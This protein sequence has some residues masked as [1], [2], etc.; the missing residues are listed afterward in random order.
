MF[1]TALRLLVKNLYR[2]EPGRKLVKA[3]TSACIDKEISGSESVVLSTVTGNT[4]FVYHF[5]EDLEFQ[6][7]VVDNLL[8]QGFLLNSPVFEKVVLWDDEWWNR[9]SRDPALPEEFG[10]RKEFFRS[11]LSNESVFKTFME[12]KWFLERASYSESLIRELLQFDVWQ[13]KLLRSPEFIAFAQNSESLTA[14]MLQ[15]MRVIEQ[16]S[17]SK[18]FLSK[19]IS[20][21]QSRKQIIDI[22]STKRYYYSEYLKYAGFQRKLLNDASV[23]RMLVNEDS[24]LEKLFLNKRF[25]QEIGRNEGVIL[26]VLKQKLALQISVEKSDYVDRLLRDNLAIQKINALINSG[27]TKINFGINNCGLRQL[28]LQSKELLDLLFSDEDWLNE[29]LEFGLFKPL[30]VNAVIKSSSIRTLLIENTAFYDLVIRDKEFTDALMRNADYHQELLDHSVFWDI[31]TSKEFVQ[32]LSSNEKALSRL[33]SK[34]KFLEQ[35]LESR[36]IDKGFLFSAG[37][38]DFYNNSSVL[39]LLSCSS[40]HV[41]SL[42]NTR[43]FWN[44]YLVADEELNSLIQRRNLLIRIL[45]SKQIFKEIVS[46]KDLLRAIFGNTEVLRFYFNEVLKTNFEAFDDDTGIYYFVNPERNGNVKGNEVFIRK[47]ASDVGLCEL[48]VGQ[49][50]FI[51]S[52]VSNKKFLKTLSGSDVVA[53]E[54]AKSKPFLDKYFRFISSDESECRDL[55]LGNDGLVEKSINETNSLNRIAQSIRVKDCILGSSEFVTWILGDMRTTSSIRVFLQSI[56]GRKEIL[57]FYF[58]EIL[59]ENLITFDDGSWIGCFFDVSIEANHEAYAEFF[60]WIASDNVLFGLFTDQVN[61]LRSLVAN[62][63]FISNL[64]GSEAVAR[65]LAKSK[66]FLDRYFKFVSSDNPDYRDLYLGFDGLVEKSINEPISLERIVASKRV[67]D[68]ILARADFVNHLRGD[69]GYI[70][71]LLERN[72][73]LFN[74]LDSKRDYSVLNKSYNLNEL[75]HKTSEVFNWVELLEKKD[76]VELLRLHQKQR[77]EKHVFLDLIRDGDWVTICSCKLKFIDKNS[78]WTLIHEIFI[79]EDY[80]FKT[81]KKIPTIIDCGSHVGFSICYFKTKFPRS[82]IF[83]FEPNKLNFKTL[84]SNVAK[85]EW[86]NVKMHEVALGRETGEMQFYSSSEDS[87]AGRLNEGKEDRS[88]FVKGKVQVE[89]LSSYITKTIDMLKM[90]I[91]GAEYDVIEEIETKLH[92]VRNMYVEIHLDDDHSYERFSSICELLIRNGFNIRF[93]DTFWENM[94]TR[95]KPLGRLTQRKTVSLFAHKSGR[96]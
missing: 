43:E 33:F 64:S 54:L 50:S 2:F 46:N 20:Y 90:D 66:P 53:R 93:K 59:K 86:K 9:M 45:R 44:T 52:A 67:R 71:K 84:K 23:M 76:V 61:V 11:V 27:V 21:E 49:A 35:L 37:F 4:E 94:L 92:L 55:F 25:L 82:K 41:K 39:E 69:V 70:G 56:F 72:F 15:S 95:Q 88:R 74:I 77:D 18:E 16:A 32:A 29:L 87:M 10:S 89:R 3:F 48:L 83:A 38:F 24:W 34:E 22:V 1:K 58:Q 51:R 96:K 19:L 30:V 79:E 8:F 65:E 13:N 60:Q 14:H 5:A 36:K 73:N 91:E 62:N 78:L 17:I 57:H 80:W 85:N 6:G 26:H 68:A 12:G 42:V 28:A 7:K 40:I 31:V 63:H 81:R 47:V 75:V